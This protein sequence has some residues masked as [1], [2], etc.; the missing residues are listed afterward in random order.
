MAQIPYTRLKYLR[1]GFAM[2]EMA[3][4]FDKRFKYVGND[5]YI[6]KMAQVFDKPLN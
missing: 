2:L 5:I 6:W 4:E 3:S 1:N